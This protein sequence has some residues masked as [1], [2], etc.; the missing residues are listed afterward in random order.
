MA[1]ESLEKWVPVIKSHADLV[2]AVEKAFDYRGDVTIILKSGEKIVGYIYNRDHEAKE[3]YLEY[4]PRGVDEQKSLKYSEI[5]GFSPP[6]RYGLES[7]GRRSNGASALSLPFPI[8]CGGRQTFLPALPAL[9]GHLH[10]CSFQHRILCLAHPYDRS[11]HGIE[12]WRI[13]TYAR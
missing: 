2:D 1:R 12:G 13:C 8:L 6:R 11:G 9:S 4:Y 5:A 7:R 10:R 3:P